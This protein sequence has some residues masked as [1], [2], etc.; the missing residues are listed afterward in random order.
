[1]NKNNVLTQYDKDLRLRR[2]YPEARREI[3]GEVVRFIRQAPGQ[4]F[5]SFTFANEQQ[6]DRVI[7]REL[8]Y[9][10]PLQQPLTWKVYEHDRLPS[11]KDKLTARSFMEEGGE[12]VMMLDLR[13]T[14]ALLFRNSATGAHNMVYRRGDGTI[15]W[16][17]PNR[18]G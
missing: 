2:M 8:D 3:T 6:L 12:A 4:N 17:E 14:Q 1:M 7:D 15:G 5:V 16:V 11:L 10:A 9:F 13:N 18:A